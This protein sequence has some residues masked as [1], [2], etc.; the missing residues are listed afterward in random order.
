MRLLPHEQEAI[1]DA[2]ATIQAIETC[3]WLDI[4]TKPKQVKKLHAKNGINKPVVEK[5]ND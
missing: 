2:I 5:Q 1:I 4:G 3:D